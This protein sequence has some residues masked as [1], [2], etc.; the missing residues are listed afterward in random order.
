MFKIKNQFFHSLTPCS[1]TEEGEPFFLPDQG[2]G[3]FIAACFLKYLT[4]TKGYEVLWD[5]EVFDLN[6]G[7][8]WL[9]GGSGL[10]WASDERESQR[11]REA[12]L[13]SMFFDN[14][15]FL[16]YL[17]SNLLSDECKVQSDPRKEKQHQHRGETEIDTLITRTTRVKLNIWHARTLLGTTQL[18]NM[19][20]KTD[21]VLHGWTADRI[22]CNAAV[23]ERLNPYYLTR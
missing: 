22:K 4:V 7:C 15:F 12:N 21:N 1:L 10:V 14:V 18:S 5:R 6:I 13:H 3:G 11:V 8:S 9:S 20:R 17:K 19:I 16:P 2:R 23:A